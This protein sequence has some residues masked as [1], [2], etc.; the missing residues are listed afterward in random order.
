MES[1]GVVQAL[2][3]IPTEG[4]KYRF[5]VEVQ[6]V[7]SSCQKTQ[8]C[9]AAAIFG[10]D[11]PE[12]QLGRKAKQQGCAVHQGQGGGRAERWEGGAGRGWRGRRGVQVLIIPPI[13]SF[14][15]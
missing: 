9:A 1:S 13:S 10:L 5:L 8:G 6:K 14:S 3:R 4:E 15:L 12:E 2:G 11:N 7:T